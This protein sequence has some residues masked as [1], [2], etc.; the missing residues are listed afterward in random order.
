MHFPGSNLNGSAALLTVYVMQR[1]T[2]N[3]DET[4][5]AETE[6]KKKTGKKSR[7]KRKLSKPRQSKNNL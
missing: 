3:P 2:K 5:E 1:L 6:A 4:L 7:R